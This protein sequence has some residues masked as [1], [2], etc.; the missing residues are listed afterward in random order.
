MRR[1]DKR[2]MK[3]LTASG[4]FYEYLP[5]ADTSCSKGLFNHQDGR[6]VLPV[7][8]MYGNRVTPAI[9]QPIKR[10]WTFISNDYR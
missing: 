10:W 4:K 7:L 1:L 6:N 8:P 5:L 2:M 9:L 3:A